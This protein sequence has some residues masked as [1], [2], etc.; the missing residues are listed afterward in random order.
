MMSEQAIIML[1]NY[2]VAK[3]RE[4]TAVKDEN[5]SFTF[6]YER[7]GYA[8]RAHAYGICLEYYIDKISNDIYGNLKEVTS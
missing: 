5:T 2:N 7:D 4:Y 1:Y 3:Y 8:S 6:E